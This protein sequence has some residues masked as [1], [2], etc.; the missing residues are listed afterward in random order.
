V[1]EIIIL[2]QDIVGNVTGKLKMG[3]IIKIKKNREFQKI[4]H[5]GR[6]A[7]SKALVIYMQPNLLNVNRIGI[8]A[9]KKY[10][11]SVK[12]NRIRRLIRE[13]YHVLQDKIRQGYDFIIVARK[14]DENDVP[15]FVQI[16]KEMRFILKRLNVLS[17]N[18]H[19]SFT[20]SGPQSQ[21]IQNN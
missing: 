2:K 8:T 11:K 19:A 10:G 4:Y 3:K 15:G 17:E 9:S 14:A 21:N 13:S 7:V 5:K 1:V 12:R 6:Y 16:L 20:G 18:N